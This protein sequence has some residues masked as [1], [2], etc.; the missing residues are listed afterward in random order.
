MDR[1]TQAGNGKNSLIRK[2][3]HR[4]WILPVAGEVVFMMFRSRL[5]KTTGV[6]QGYPP[7]E[8][9]SFR[10]RKGARSVGASAA[11]A[12]VQGALWRLAGARPRGK[13]GQ[14]WGGRNG[15]NGKDGTRRTGNC[16]GGQQDATK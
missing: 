10:L 13:T 12:G 7:I 9:S 5:A 2:A 4:D 14:N 15:N 11:G 3:L 1:E 8:H 16:N 6:G